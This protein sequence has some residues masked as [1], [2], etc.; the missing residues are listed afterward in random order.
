MKTHPLLYPGWAVL[1]GGL[2]WTGARAG[3]DTPPAPPPAPRPHRLQPHE[4]IPPLEGT[5][6]HSLFDGRTL[7]GWKI[8]DYA[9]H[10]DV[11]VEDGNLVME[12]G[13]MLTGVNG[14]TNLF[15]TNYELVYDAKRVM[16]T[17][18][19]GTVTFPV[20]TNCC[21]LVLGGWGG[22][23]VGISSLD[24]MDASENSTSVFL[25]FKENRWYRVRVRVTPKRLQ[26]W[27]GKLEVVNELI[28]DHRITVRPGEIEM[29]Q[30]FGFSTW[31]TTG[32]LRHIKWRSLD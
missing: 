23:V 11:K 31:V 25:D 27:V 17:D 4:E 6:W 29:S 1:L 3:D 8:T 26:C 21:S 15:R 22:G 24:G 20:G 5:G 2:L 9:G 28:A 19:F 12:M 16:G 10:G 18:F 7:K 32:A 13:A 30:P 14:P